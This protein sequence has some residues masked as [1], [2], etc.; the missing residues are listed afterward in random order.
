MTIDPKNLSST[1]TLTFADEFDTLSLRING[2]GTWD[3]NYYWGAANGVTLSNNGELEWYIDANYA[4]TSAVKPWTV[5]NGVLDITAAP[6]AADIKPLI[7]NYD[8]TS[9]TLTTYHTFS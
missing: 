3:T 2:S 1:A 8:Y 6:A 9:G 5:N 7:N 4:P